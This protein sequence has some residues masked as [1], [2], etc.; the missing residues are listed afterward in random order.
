MKLKEHKD[1]TAQRWREFPFYKQILMIASELQR[2]NSWIKRGDFNEVRLCYERALELIFLTIEVLP[3]NPEDNRLRELLRF[4]ELLQ[5]EYIKQ[6]LSIESNQKL[7]STLISLSS[8]SY[9]LLNPS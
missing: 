7:F 3:R 9:N 2:A 1:L 8:E 6:G 5:Q 4:R